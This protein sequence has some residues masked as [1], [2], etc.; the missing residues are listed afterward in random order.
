MSNTL[1][2]KL[3][4]LGIPL[5]PEEVTESNVTRRGHNKR[6]WAVRFRGGYAVGDLASNIKEYAFEEGF[7]YNKC[8][9][10]IE[11]ARQKLAQKRNEDNTIAVS[12]A[13]QIWSTASDCTT[14]PY[15]ETKK[16]KAY[17]LKI[18]RQTLLIPLHDEHGNLASLQ[19][20]WPNPQISGKF[21]K[22]FLKGSKIQGCCF[23]LGAIA[24]EVVICE[25]YATGATIHEIT[26]LPVVVAF[27]SNNLKCVAVIIAKKHPKAKITIAAD[28]DR[29]KPGNPGL[30]KAK[31]AAA[32]VKARL[33][34]PEFASDNGEPTDFNDLYVNEGA[35]KVNNAFMANGCNL[36][37]AEEGRKKFDSDPKQYLHSESCDPNISKSWPTQKITAAN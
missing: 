23:T 18:D 1:Y 12:Q 34:V 28:N 16:I 37:D 24:D 21:V 2:D 11:E 7:N 4:K 17:G 30:T 19:K 25:G 5:P 36:R 20:I 29:F 35:E 13:K 31:E 9:R 26:G 8:R 10:Q 27:S 15:L 3:Q 33:V 14:H 32:A 22:G 6:Y